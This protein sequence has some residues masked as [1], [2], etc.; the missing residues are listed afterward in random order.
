MVDFKRPDVYLT[1]S[2]AAPQAD[3]GVSLSNGCFVSPHN[4]G[5]LD[6]TLVTS[7]SQFT[8]LYGGFSAGSAAADDLLYA[9]YQFFNN[10][11]RQCYV[12]RVAEGS[13]TVADA[14]FN[15]SEGT[16]AVTFTVAATNPGAW[17]NGISVAVTPSA[18]DANRFT[19]TVYVG[20]TGATNVVERF[21]DLTMDPADQ[22][23][24]EAV[25]NSPES[26]SIYIRV[27]DAGL[28]AGDPALTLADVTPDATGTGSGPS[29]VVVP[30]SLT[31]GTDSGS[32]PATDDW[33]DALAKVDAI[34]S[35]LTL[36]FPGVTSSTLINKALAYAEGR[37]DVF[38]VID[39]VTASGSTPPTVAGQISAAAAYSAGNL[40]YGACYFPRPVIADPAS[41]SPGATRVVPAGGAVVGQFVANDALN[42][43]QKTPAGLGAR[44]TNAVGLEIPLNNNDLDTL[45]L[46]NINAIRSLPG[47]GVVIFGGR[48]LTKTGRADK[49][50]SVRRTLILLK[51]EMKRL[52]QFAL[53]E[54]NGYLLWQQVSNVLDQYLMGFWTTGGLSG[55]TAG[56]AFYVVCDE[57]NNTPQT[58]ANGELHID[59]GVAPQKPA[60]FIAIKV[61]QY[62][63]A[64]SVAEAA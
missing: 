49:Y 28:M 10:S 57:S 15:D 39:G 48:T 61:S 2:L 17:G 9:V 8:S 36:N 32:A 56:Q 5:P 44:I 52:T 62:D 1:E 24:I 38:V 55:D 33:D 19:L 63:G 21:M 11:G 29:F 64:V 43:V 22:R 27:T 26:G 42:G 60:E 30:V 51:A 7:F 35:P 4:R 16:P 34:D 40:S 45:N 6:A 3:T 37:G 25:V 23:Y 50:I 58:V 46:S 47:S 31:G 12:V 54:P 18:G 41:S 13:E 14:E 20:G 59:V 53:F